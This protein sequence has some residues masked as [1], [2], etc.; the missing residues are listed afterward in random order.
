MTKMEMLRD[1][2][3]QQT[4]AIGDEFTE[5]NDDWFQAAFFV[6]G[7]DIKTVGLPPMVFASSFTKDLFGKEILPGMI[8]DLQADAYALLNNTWMV[9]IKKEDAERD[10][11]P[12]GS[13]E[14]VEGRK[15]M[16]WLTVAD[17]HNHEAWKAE[18]TRHESGPPTLGEWEKCDYDF[19][20]GRFIDE[21]MTAL[22]GTEEK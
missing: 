18:I 11:L 14:H 12:S 8:R 10:G 17:K 9:E 15:E 5:P 2:V 6:T 3:Q 1:V 21:P 7:N 20:E 19:I 22:R 13:L 16:L 4:K